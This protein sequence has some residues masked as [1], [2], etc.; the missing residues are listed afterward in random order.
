MSKQQN[1]IFQ[2]KKLMEFFFFHFLS[3][4]SDC[5][6][7]RCPFHRRR[8][9]PDPLG[10][11]P[12]RPHKGQTLCGFVRRD[13]R[14]GRRVRSSQLNVEVLHNLRTDGRGVQQPAEGDVGKVG[15]RQRRDDQ[16]TAQTCCARN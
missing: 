10:L 1:F 6:K 4:N 5:F 2:I 16:L 15:R 8:R 12:A 14:L 13:P 9:L 11:H 3:N 7:R